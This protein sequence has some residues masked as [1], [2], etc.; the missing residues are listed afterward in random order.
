M[1]SAVPAGLGS[2]SVTNRHYRAGLSH[3]VPAALG[4]RQPVSWSVG[5]ILIHVILAVGS[6]TCLRINTG[7]SATGPS[8]KGRNAKARH[9]VPGTEAE[10]ER[11]PF[12]DGT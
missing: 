9:G 2:S 4:R 5:G 1:N 8:P 6:V 7:W 3:I 12:R 10:G 11:V